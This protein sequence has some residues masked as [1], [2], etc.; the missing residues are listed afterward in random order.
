MKHGVSAAGSPSIFKERKTP[1]LV[2]LL[3]RAILEN[4]ALLGYYAACGGNFFPTFRNNLSVPYSGVK[5]TT[6]DET[7][8]LSGSVCKKL[9]PRAA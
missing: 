7:D 8:R 5:M 2:D 6:E 1:K 3:D 4:C 9:P